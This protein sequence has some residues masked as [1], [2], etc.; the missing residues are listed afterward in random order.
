LSLLVLPGLLLFLLSLP[1]SI[2][3]GNHFVTVTVIVDL[4]LV[5]D[6]FVEIHHHTVV[7][8]CHFPVLAV[9]VYLNQSQG[10]I[11]LLILR[12]SIV[13]LKGDLAFE[14]DTA[15][16]HINGILR[17]V[18]LD[19]THIAEESKVGLREHGESFEL[20]IID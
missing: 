1:L 13:T 12:S 18:D 14:Q 20:L 2:S 8:T 5:M 15:I 9:S 7:I 6:I 10:F 17:L 11:F 4:D 16:L 3:L 19:L